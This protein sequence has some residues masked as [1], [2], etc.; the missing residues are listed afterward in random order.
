[1]GKVVIGQ[2]SDAW[3]DTIGDTYRTFWISLALF[4]STKSIS[5]RRR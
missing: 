4:T 3:G 2:I 1:M 5:R